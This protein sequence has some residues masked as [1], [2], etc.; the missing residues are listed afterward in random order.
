[1]TSDVHLTFQLAELAALP[2]PAPSGGLYPRIADTLAQGG[3]QCGNVLATPLGP[4]VD[5]DLGMD[6]VPDR[7]RRRASLGAVALLT[8][9]ALA[10]WVIIRPQPVL[11]AGMISGRLVLSPA[12]PR[13]GERV[14]VRYSA[15]ALF[16]RPERL[17]LRGRVRTTAAE[18]YEQGVPVI[19]LGTLDRVDGN[20]YRG[21]FVLPD[22]FVFAALAVED[23][24]ATEVDD[25][26][27]RAWEVLRA[28]PDGRPLLDA[29]EQRAHDLMGRSWEEGLATARRMASLYPDS[30][31]AVKWLQV[32]ELWMG[33][34]TDSTRAV[35]LR[36][37][38]RF[39]ERDLR[40]P[41]SAHELGEHFWFVR[42]LDTSLALPWRQRLLREAPRSG[43]AVQEELIDVQRLVATG[44]IDS[45][46]AV[47]RLDMLWPRVP[48]ERV[49]QI[50]GAALSLLGGR[51]ERAADLR[52]WIDRVQVATPRRAAAAAS[53]RS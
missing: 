43:L 53:P 17:R 18:S 52:R 20:E 6:R 44:R 4:L 11:E 24:L 51:S 34:A 49:G 46:A 15:G 13:A 27:G 7:R 39:A 5:D 12:S 29:L 41:M 30:V 40:R 33:I 28:G 36:N 14:E 47:Q 23:T 31:R 1:M 19:T 8:A 48:R 2:E 37:A 42:T 32:Y 45:A 22:S 50:G 25:F 21:Q 10:L 3:D 16:G 38:Q 35:H 9:A 26:G